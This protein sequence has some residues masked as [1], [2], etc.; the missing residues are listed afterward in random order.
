MAGFGFLNKEGASKRR[1]KG[2]VA[3]LLGRQ[4]VAGLK[5]IAVYGLFGNKID[6]KDWMHA[7]P[8]RQH[9]DGD[10][11]GIFWFDYMADSGDGQKSVYNIA[12]LCQSDLWLR[13]PDAKPGSNAV[14][15]N[16]P[17]DH[18]RLPRG[19]FLFV[20]GD[21]AYHI[22]D[23]PTLAERFQTPF[24][25]AYDDLEANGKT[26][27]RSPIY[28]I[29]GN[30]DYY[31][32]LDGFNRQFKRPLSDEAGNQAPNDPTQPHLELKGFTRSQTASYVALELPFNWWFWGMDTQKGLIDHRQRGFFLD[33]F[34]QH[35]F[36]DDNYAQLETEVPDKLIV[37]TP[38]PS[39]TFGQWADM[40]DAISV[41]FESLGLETSFLRSKNGR[42]SPRKCRLDISGDVHH[43]TRYWG[44]PDS[45][46]GNYA[47]VVAGGGGAFLHPSHTDVGEVVNARRYPSRRDSHRVMTRRLLNPL[48]ILRGGYIWLAGAIL[49]LLSYYAVA[50][51]E[52]TWALLKLI[53]Y[54]LRPCGTAT[55]C[56]TDGGLLA[57]I[58]VALDVRR[59]G[60]DS[61]F[62]PYIVDLVYA[63]ALPVFLI[64]W[65]RRVPE[66]FEEEKYAE[67]TAWLRTMRGF[68]W[69]PVAAF[70]PMLILI[71]WPWSKVA[72]SFPASVIIALFAIAAIAL[73]SMIRRYSDILIERAKRYRGHLTDSVPIWILMLLAGVSISYGFLRYGTFPASVM[74]FD[75]VFAMLLIGIFVGLTAM[76]A[77][78]GG[79]LLEAKGKAGFGLLGL[80][81]ASLHF[82][83][84]MLMAVFASG[85]TILATM[86]VVVVLTFVASRLFTSGFVVGD[87][88]GL[89]NQGRIAR[90]LLI[91][92]IVLGVGTIVAASWGGDPHAVSWMRICGAFFLG[93]FFSCIWF[94]WYLAVCLAFNGHNNEAGGGARAERYRHFV[95]FRVEEDVLTG[96][97]IGFD[98]PVEDFRKE[99]P[100][101]ELI[102]VFTVRQM[103]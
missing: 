20:G 64:F 72:P 29:P 71:A 95:R 45:A 91:V 88:E 79:K 48:N 61:A 19:A 58:Q 40:N 16:D 9:A 76:A 53:P 89:A 55:G 14:I 47:S 70:V 94:G 26:T 5:W 41:S 100:A 30:H 6:P 99:T 87:D 50:I 51:P 28:G 59:L 3:W 83:V 93:L 33:T 39:T 103:R 52:S 46:A 73:L 66:H 22:A 12:Y 44:E 7:E 86:A 62:L 65:A 80:W 60:V 74:N 8:D 92:W 38:E 56:V 42:L 37:A 34:G 1:F 96:Y 85:T 32:A 68:L 49:G 78:V 97:V 2:P 77:L 15:L 54:E 4:L 57:R 90:M 43:Y 63:L 82:C 67:R 25:W 36:H 11:D 23:Y 24:N 81:H 10:E 31:D 69:P 27:A 98:E 84:P 101:F 35:I 18:Y 13:G 21:T 17:G 102:D 75:F